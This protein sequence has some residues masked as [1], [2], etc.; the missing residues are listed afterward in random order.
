MSSK[1]ISSIQQVTLLDTFE[2]LNGDL[3]RYLT[4]K[5]GCSCLAQDL[6]QETYLRLKENQKHSS[7]IKNP[8]AYVYKIAKNLVFDH[9]RRKQVVD[10]YAHDEKSNL[11][12]LQYTASLENIIEKDERVKTLYQ[13]I[14]DLPSKCR[15]VFILSKFEGLTYTEISK[16][17]N[18]SVSAVEKHMMKGLAHC[19]DRFNNTYQKD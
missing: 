3:V 12:K 2:S 1:A 15:K 17:L 4:Y 13:A 14:N 11:N 7:K 9:L 6:Y 18:I 8:K 5:V 19:R 16:K 10:R